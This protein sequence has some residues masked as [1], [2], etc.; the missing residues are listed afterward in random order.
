[1]EVAQL[2]QGKNYY[3]LWYDTSSTPNVYYLLVSGTVGCAGRN[4]D[5]TVRVNFTV[6]RRDAV[7]VFE[8][9]PKPALPDL[10]YES[11]E[12]FEIDSLGNHLG[13]E[14]NQNIANNRAGV[15]KNRFFK[16]FYIW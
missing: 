6:Y 16:L 5:S 7:V 10:W 11:A 3:R 4:G 2:L 8:T 12:S 9:E 1:M 13:N 14:L 15:V